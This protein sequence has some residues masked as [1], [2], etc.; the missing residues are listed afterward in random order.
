[1]T[2]FSFSY[3]RC[4]AAH[5]FHSFNSPAVLRGS[6]DA[7]VLSL[8]SPMRKPRFKEVKWLSRGNPLSWCQHQNSTSV[9]S[10]SLLWFSVH[11][12]G[13]IDKMHCSSLCRKSPLLGHEDSFRT[14]QMQRMLSIGRSSSVDSLPWNFTATVEWET[15]DTYWDHISISS[16]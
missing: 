12:C 3:S 1:M 16:S 5:S 13:L 11:C 9:C 6:R 14:V 2:S 8:V 7:D 10:P 4:P 15:W